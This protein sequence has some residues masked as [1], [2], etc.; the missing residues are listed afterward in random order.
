MPVRSEEWVLP[1]SLPAALLIVDGLVVIEHASSDSRTEILARADRRRVHVLRENDPVVHEA[2]LRQRMLDRGR[3][4]G[5]THFLQIDADE[6]ITANLVP[7]VRRAF[8]RLAPGETLWMPW[9]HLWDGLDR[10]RD[11]DS[12]ISSHRMIAGFRDAP[13]IHFVD[14]RGYD[15]HRREPVGTGRQRKFPRTF[16]DG[17]LLH[18]AFASWRRLV[19]KMAWYKMIE[20]LR[21]SEYSEVA[22]IDRRYSRDVDECVR[23]VPVPRE[24]WAGYEPWRRGVDLDSQS[25]QESECVTMWRR[26]G[27]ARFRGLNLWDVPQKA[28]QASSQG[29][30]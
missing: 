15:I 1:L 10:L 27:A 2:R 11:D 8:S 20:V 22:E 19:S 12:G 3:E 5:A 23:T 14:N 30:V 17:G 25:W 18:L 29:G 26:E 6:V 9:L 21:F 4:I 28:A 7:R 16:R 24:W 13:E